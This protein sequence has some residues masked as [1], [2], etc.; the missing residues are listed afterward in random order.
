M[1]PLI[2]HFDRKGEA[3][4]SVDQS[5]SVTIVSLSAATNAVVAIPLDA[6]FAIFQNLNQAEPI[7]AKFDL[8]AS[9][10]PSVPDVGVNQSLMINPDVRRIDVKNDSGVNNAIHLIAENATKVVINFYSY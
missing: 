7:Y 3:L 10:F 9:V 5:D 1:K 4:D 6:R 2:N 8:P